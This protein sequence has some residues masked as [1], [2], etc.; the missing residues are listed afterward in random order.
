[1]ARA[2]RWSG[3]RAGRPR[4]FVAK[5]LADEPGVE[6]VYIQPG[7]AGE[8]GGE[9]PDAARFRRDVEVW[10]GRPIRVIRN[11]RYQDHWD[12]FMQRGFIKGPRGALCTRELKRE[13][14]MRFERPDDVQVFGYTME[15]QARADSFRLNNPGVTLRTPLIEHGL[16]KEDCLG[17][18]WQAEIELHEMYRLGYS[19][20]N[21]IGCVKGGMGYWNKIRR[22]FPETFETASAVERHVGHAILKDDDGP[23]WL[24]TLDPDRGR[25]EDEPSIS[26]GLTCH[27]LALTMQAT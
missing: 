4:R 6:V 22:D 16:T 17:L 26:C 8:T 24:N 25:I 11:E 9:H 3:S 15:E 20:A 19:N 18:L 2:E 5:L 10:I 13:V 23:V 12:A 7:T 27:G 1:M 21:C 14:R